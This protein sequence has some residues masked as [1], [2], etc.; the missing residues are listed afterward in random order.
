LPILT[1]VLR[2][3]KMGGGRGIAGIRGGIIPTVPVTDGG[4]YLSLQNIEIP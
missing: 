2:H 4:G 1:I 3:R